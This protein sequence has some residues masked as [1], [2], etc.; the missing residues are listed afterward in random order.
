MRTRSATPMTRRHMLQMI[1][2]GGTATLIAACSPSAPA[3]PT[4]A[5]KPTSAPAASPS[6]APAASPGAAASP[7]AAAKPAAPSTNA[8][9]QEG[10]FNI[11]TYAGAGYRKVVEAFQAAYPNI[12]VEHSQFQSSSREFVP[13]LLQE[14]KAGLKSWDV[15][16]MPP[17]EQLRQTRPAGGLD[18]I[19]PTLVRADVLDDAAWVDGF[20]AGFHDVEQRWG[21]AL[22]VSRSQAVWVNTQMVKDG[23]I[24]TVQDLLNPKWK[25]KIIG[26]DPRSRGSGFSPAMVMRL[27]TGNDDIIRLLYKEQEV[28]LTTD[29]RQPTEFMVRGRYAVSIGAVDK[30]ILSDFRA[31][32]LGENLKPLIMPDV[33]YLTSSFNAMWLCKDAMHPNAAKVWINWALGKEA[34]ALWGPSLED[35]SRRADVAAYDPSIAA[36][37]GDPFIISSHET[38]LDEADKTQKIASDVLN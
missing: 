33:D 19:R 34:G 15:W 28:S 25:G 20:E 24:Q 7:A 35:N 12:A 2:L 26:A 13:R 8:A 1:G 11:A 4:A 37:R 16:L 23:E 14:M 21:Y 29:A 9:N 31:E 5:A 32:G 27:K 3:S 17:Q 30:H 10:H 22:T 6:T 36:K 18:P 38:M